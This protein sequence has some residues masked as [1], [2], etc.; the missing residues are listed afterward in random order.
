MARSNLQREP[1]IEALSDPLEAAGYLNAAMEEGN[2]DLYLLALRNV[3]E[4]RI[5]GITK[6][7]MATGL[8]RDSL[9]QMLSEDDD[10]GLK[11]IDR[12]LHALGLKISVEV[13][14]DRV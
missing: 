7:S 12:L 2:K 13:D 11:D 10:P 14:G 6:L 5:G 4:A 8:N 1:L 3:V 9:Y